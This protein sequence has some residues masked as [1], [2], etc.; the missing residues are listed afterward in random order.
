MIARY[1]RAEMGRIWSDE[2]RFAQWLEVE[3]AAAAVE[4]EM[5]IIPAEAAAEI[6][7]KAACEPARIA[8]IEAEVKHDLIAFTTNVAEHVGPA[9]RYFHYG[10]T[11]NDTIDTAQALQIQQASRLIAAGL[12]ALGQVL[13]RRAREFARTPAVGRT[14]GV[15]AEPITFGLKFAN[16]YTE[17]VR[18]QRR[19]SAAAEDLRVGKIS[20]AVGTFAHLSP[21]VEARICRRL[22]LQPAPI[23]NQVIQR[24]RHAAFLCTLAV[25]GS[26]LDKIALEIRHLQRTEVREA[27]EYFSEKQKGSSAMPHKRNPVTCEQI[28]GLARLLRSNSQAALENVALWHERDIS[29]SSVERVILPDSCILAD[30]L[31]AKTTD[32]LDKLL[33][34]PEQMQRNLDLTHGLVFS[35]QLLLELVESGVSRELA[36]RWVQRHAMETW[37][38]GQD[39]RRLIEAD[40]EI[41]AQVKPETIAAAFDL[42]RQLRHVDTILDRALAEKFPA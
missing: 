32:L 18:N 11:S 23:S 10:L 31:L 24:D 20:G 2:N 12:A 37:R 22:G 42:P 26:S 16:W 27:E 41:R 8:A 14:H 30:Y 7:A 40:P 36:Y 33:V 35:G 19:F 38:T 39:F 6:L 29:H 13:A 4:A 5:G 17:N 34:Y 21:E 9:A 3:K 25:I 28:C 1:T 15:H